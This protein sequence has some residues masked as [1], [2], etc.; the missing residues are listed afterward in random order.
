[1][2]I[3]MVAAENDALPNGKVG[4]IGDVVR[5]LPPALAA[6]G[7]V[8]N[9]VNPGYQAFSLLPGAEYITSI[10]V[11]FTGQMENIDVFKVPAIEANSNVTI[12]VVEHPLFALGGV[13]KIYCD[14]PPS[15]PFES[16]AN[17]F[18]LFSAAVAKATVS[19]V[20]GTIDVIHLHDWHAAMLAMLRAYDPEYQKLQS[21]HTVYTIHNL[22]LQGIRPL[23]GPESSLEYWFPKLQYNVDEINDPRYPHCINPMRL[24]I[25]L[26]DKIHAVSP[27]YADEIKQATDLQI[28][29]FGGEGLEADLQRADNENRLF[30]IL[31]G[32]DYKQPES[33]T[34]L[35]IAELFN[36]CEKEVLNW[37]RKNP[38]DAAI[39]LSAIKKLSRLQSIVDCNNSETDVSNIQHE[40]PI[41]ITSVGRITK[42]KM[43]L[44]QQ[45]LENGKSALE[46]LLQKLGDNGVF[47]L[48]GSGDKELEDFLSKIALENDNFILMK[49]FSII[50]ADYIYAGGDLFLMPSSFEPCGIS[51][52]LAMRAGQPCL[53]HDVGGLSDTVKNNVDGFS[54]NGAS[55]QDQANN[56]ISCFETALTL[57]QKNPGKWSELS[58][59][60][61]NAR[62]L[63]S[64][65]AADYVR[66][67]YQ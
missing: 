37:Q 8:V 38:E 43:L 16:D 67:L 42:Q 66:L 41:I 59:S 65:V 21:I 44:F 28:G 30:G 3:L 57:K 19:E 48:L 50:L 24:A 22:S 12:W 55:L 25:N 7:H 45:V 33:D 46:N 29:F 36:V 4:G 6:A 51:Q 20:F 27:T 64:D 2:K 31:N 17:K 1:M 56:L 26:S 35:S 54:F 53:V 60:A 47:L 10:Q 14:D 15:R 63:W 34:S 61:A 5:D 32:C 9:V 23:Q 40:M 13:G 18:A 62:F 58:T 39:H 11:Q 52:M 49:G